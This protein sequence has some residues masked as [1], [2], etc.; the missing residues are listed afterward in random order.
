M[1]NSW[2]RYDTKDLGLDLDTNILMNILITSVWC[3]LYIKQHLSY[4]WGSIHENVKEHWGWAEKSVVYK[5]GLYKQ[6]AFW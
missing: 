6:T 4:I 3:C 5:K 1:K 2:H